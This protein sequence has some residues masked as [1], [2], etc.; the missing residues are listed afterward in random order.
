MRKRGRGD[1][2]R[3]IDG[4][5][6]GLQSGNRIDCGKEIEKEKV[7]AKE[8]YERK[9]LKSLIKDSLFVP[10]QARHEECEGEGAAV[11]N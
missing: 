5:R 3:K 7:N 4:N 1:A 9:H 8:I 10:R 11:E 2:R 6:E